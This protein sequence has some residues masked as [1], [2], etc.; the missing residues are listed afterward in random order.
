MFS[1]SNINL[2]LQ[3]ST[4]TYNKRFNSFFYKFPI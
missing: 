3:F 2:I 1:T 4:S